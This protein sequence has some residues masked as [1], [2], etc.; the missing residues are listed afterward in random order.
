MEKLSMTKLEAIEKIKNYG[1]KIF[2]VKFI[3][4]DGST[5][6]MNCRLHVKKGVTGVGMRYDPLAKGLLPV[7]DMQK[8]EFRMINLKTILSLTFESNEYIVI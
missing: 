6:V 1:S 8:G 4:L 7:F 2:T 3:K 5:R